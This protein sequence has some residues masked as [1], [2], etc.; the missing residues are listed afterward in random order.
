MFSSTASRP[1]RLDAAGLEAALVAIA[2]MDREELC[3]QLRYYPATFP[4]DFTDLFL[5]TQ[6]TDRL[7]HIVARLGGDEFALLF[8]DT[9]V[10]GAKAV[11]EKLVPL[12]AAIQMENTHVTCSIGAVIFTRPPARPVEAMQMADALMYAIKKEGKDAIAF[13]IFDGKTCER[14]P[15]IH[16]AEKDWGERRVSNPLPPVPQTGALP[17]ELRPPCQ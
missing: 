12:L 14:Q 2:S 5:A 8:P 15:A 11:L 10:S 7:R 6:S 1:A 17:S 4:L 16:T 13:G 3:E 9:G